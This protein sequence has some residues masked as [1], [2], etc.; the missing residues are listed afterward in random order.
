MAYPL[1]AE[2]DEQGHPKQQDAE[3]CW[4]NVLTTIKT[5]HNS[6]LIKNLFEVEFSCKYGEFLIPIDSIIRKL[7]KRLRPKPR[8]WLRKSHATLTMKT[9]P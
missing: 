7:L 4:T 8:K 5:L 6:E 3:E 2:V 1:F 9:I